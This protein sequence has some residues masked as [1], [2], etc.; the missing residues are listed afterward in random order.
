MIELG[1]RKLGLF[2]SFKDGLNEIVTKTDRSEEFM[3]ER[4]ELIEKRRYS[5]LCLLICNRHR[6]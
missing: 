1:M 6:R 4:E 5:N 3:D 2:K